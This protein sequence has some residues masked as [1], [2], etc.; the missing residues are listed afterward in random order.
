MRTVQ[1]YSNQQ[2]TEM[3]EAFRWSEFRHSCRREQ[4]GSTMFDVS[5]EVQDVSKN[6]FSHEVLLLSKA[7]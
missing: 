3:E 2:N 4:M 6:R 1:D 5:R 7:A